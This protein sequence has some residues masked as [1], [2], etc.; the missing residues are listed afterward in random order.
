LK[1][2]FNSYIHDW[3]WQIYDELVKNYDIILP[4]NYK[5]KS[6]K[7]TQVDLDALEKCVKENM[8]A[9]FI[10]D[11][12]GS[13]PKLIE[14]TKREI[15]KPLILFDTNVIFRPY[16]AKR[17]LFAHIWYVELYAKPLMQKYNKDN[18]IYQGMAANPNIF[19]PIETEKVYDVTF[20]GQHY[21]ERAYWIKE[22]EN[23]CQNHKIKYFFPKG[24][25]EKVPWSFEDI[26]KFYSQ[27][28][29]NIA[30]APH[31][32]L[33][34]RIV[35]RT[36]EIC[37][38]GNFQLLQYT[39][40]VEQY[41]E[42]DKEIVCWKNKKEL[43]DK[44]IYYLENDSEREKIAKMARKRAV[45]D[46]TWSVR[47][48]NVKS[49]LKEKENFDISKY[50]I[51]IKDILEKKDL[52]NLQKQKLNRSIKGNLKFIKLI[53]KKFGFKIKRDFKYLDSYKI[54]LK[55]QN[56]YYYHPK[57]P[58][59]YLY[60]KLY[61]KLMMVIKVISPNSN[62][63]LT[64]LKDIKR[65]VFLNENIDYSHP[66][67]GIL[68]NGNEWIIRDFK[69]YKWLNCIPNRKA[70]KSK[71]NF[72]KFISQRIIIFIKKGEYSFI[73][74][75]LI[76]SNFLRQKIELIYRKKFKFTQY[77]YLEKRNIE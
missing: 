35:L 9:C 68:T 11:F 13:L 75:I 20:F 12:R 30:F 74:K 10:F 37:M 31:D 8:D 71:I 48:E 60:I 47:I 32:R 24:H 41:F 2:I 53:L 64:H 52:N 72:L 45:K 21:G 18:I 44:I 73:L 38:S 65:A 70:L 14:W 56:F 36:F 62:I 39:P 26:N 66:Q 55:Y 46:H 3:Y 17:T 25:G 29:I 43:F 6:N 40:A 63:N 59:T 61:G 23:F 58:E 51:N 5:D 77:R 67:F 57:D 76:P 33:G 7:N 69:N 34:R 19:Y 28:K 42:L 16:K 27:T 4:E 15:N 50:L 49:F 1:I 54:K 22:L